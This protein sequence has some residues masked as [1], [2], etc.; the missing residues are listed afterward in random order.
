MRERP[1]VE[2]AVDFFVTKHL[3]EKSICVSTPNSA[4]DFLGAGYFGVKNFET[5]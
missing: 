2:P 5:P 3:L 4:K 1:V